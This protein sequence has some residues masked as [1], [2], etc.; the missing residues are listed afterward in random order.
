MAQLGSVG[1]PPQAL[2]GSYIAPDPITGSDGVPGP[3]QISRRSDP[4]SCVWPERAPS[5]PPC[6]Y[7]CMAGTGSVGGC[8]QA[9]HGANTLR[10]SPP[11]PS[12]ISQAPDPITGS[13]GVP[14]LCMARTGSVGGCP[15]AMDSGGCL[16]E[17]G[18]SMWVPSVKP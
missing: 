12:Q 14:V 5:E 13:D 18:N 3:S 6:V 16:V 10:R 1:G 15:Q 8:P 4:R 9:I 7:V 2:H 11:A 17:Y